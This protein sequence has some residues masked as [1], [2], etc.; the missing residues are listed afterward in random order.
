MEL[1]IDLGRLF[2]EAEDRL[3]KEEVEEYEA[4]YKMLKTIVNYGSKADMLA[5]TR[6]V[7]E[8]KERFGSIE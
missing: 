6:F 3:S 5:L 1:D 8:T 2:V 4:K 7:M